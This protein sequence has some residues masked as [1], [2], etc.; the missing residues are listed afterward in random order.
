M[1]VVLTIENPFAGFDSSAVALP[2]LVMSVMQTRHCARMQKT[3]CLHRVSSAASVLEN[4][5]RTLRNV[6]VEMFWVAEVIGIIGKVAKVVGRKQ[7]WQPRTKRSIGDWPRPRARNL[8]VSVQKPRN[9]A[10][11]N[12]PKR[13]QNQSRDRTCEH[14]A[15]RYQSI[16]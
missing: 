1:V 3:T 9:G 7:T 11:R 5:L 6:H 10:N 2:T 13:I 12:L 14:L 16:S 4:N 15:A 8:S